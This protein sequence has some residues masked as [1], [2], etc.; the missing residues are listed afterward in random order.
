VDVGPGGGGLV[1]AWSVG[2]GR[3][4]KKRMKPM[5]LIPA[6]FPTGIILSYLSSERKVKHR[7]QGD[8]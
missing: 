3:R 1:P 8:K 5:V 7:K 6:S 4:E 2:G